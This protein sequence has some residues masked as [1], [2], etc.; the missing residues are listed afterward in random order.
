[1]KPYHLV[2]HCLLASLLGLSCASTGLGQGLAEL[3]EEAIRAVA[4]KLGPSVVRIETVGA[5][6][7]VEQGGVTP[8]PSTGLVVGEDGY[9]IT[10]SFPFAG[11]PA[12]VL[13]EL[14]G[15]ARSAAEIISRD[16]SRQLVLLKVDLSKVDG[17]D[18][19]QVPEAAPAAEVFPGGWSIALGRTF[20]GDQP[21]VSVGI[22]SAVNRVWGKAVQTDAK[23]SPANYGGPLVDIQGRVIG[24]L[25]PLSPTATTATEGAQWYDSGIGFA[26]PLETINKMLPLMKQGEDLKSG[27]MGITLRGKDQF[28]EAAIVGSVRPN[29]PADAAGLKAGDEVIEINGKQVN[30]QAQLKHVVSPLYAGDSVKL[31]VKRGKEQ[32]DIE[33]ELAGELQPFRMPFIG[34]LP[35]RGTEELVARA[36]WPDSPAAKAGLQTGDVIKKIGEAAV[37]NRAEVI[38]ALIANGLEKPV[39]LTVV[40]DEEELTP[41]V[42][43]ASLPTESLAELAPAPEAGEAAEDD[44]ERGELEL[45]I[46][47]FK[48]EG[49]AY[50]PENYRPDVPHGVL[51]WLHAPGDVDR[52]T[53]I[54][55]WKEICEQRHFIL[56]APLAREESEWAPD[57]VDFVRRL[58]ERLREGYTL[59]D[60][61]IV[62]HGY[63]G[64]GAMAYL[65]A[66]NNRDAVS[67]VAVVDAG[68]PAEATVPAN[69]PA[70]QLAVWMTK[71]ADRLAAARGAAMQKAFEAENYPVTVMDLGAGGRYLTA[72]ELQELAR[73]IDS[74]DRI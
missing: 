42:T 69:D 51:I 43:L 37:V 58:L 15:G 74:L 5:V 36:I 12:Q 21:N 23:I 55:R 35:Q 64:G 27:V 52:E 65:V 48:N 11:K 47:E 16:D 53:V 25:A 63:Q 8:G 19:L 24:V 56:L 40:R 30:N 4:A 60:T 17:L 14:P 2:L 20:P 3:Q 66:L 72:E 28:A 6:E 71:S 49:Y 13:V 46:A 26:V 18:K 9:I 57:E 39:R 61:R 10:S 62:T 73:W 33:M 7:V 45:K 44:I 1:M 68:L 50:V 32:V 41:E 22:V 38:E 29:T 54:Q 70:A 59:D 31:L 67:G 34:I